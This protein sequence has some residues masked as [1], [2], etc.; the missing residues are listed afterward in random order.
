MNLKKLLGWIPV[1]CL[2]TLGL[3]VLL[4]QGWI[5][6][7]PYVLPSAISVALAI[8]TVLFFDGRW[9]RGIAT[10]I[11]LRI[12]IVASFLALTFIFGSSLALLVVSFRY[13]LRISRAHIASTSGDA[14][15]SSD[16][17]SPD[18]VGRVLIA[19]AEPFYRFY[20]HPPAYFERIDT[21]LYVTITNQT[22]APLYVQGYSVVALVRGQQWRSF[23]NL[24][25]LGLDPQEIG[26]MVP[27]SS[28]LSRID[29]TENGF[30]YLMRQKPL[31]P[32]QALE[33]WMFFNSGL[34]S[35][36]LFDVTQFRITIVDST[37]KQHTFFSDYPP[38][39]DPMV[40]KLKILPREPIPP[41]LREMPSGQH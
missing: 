21:E 5:R 3:G 6:S 37:Q 23:Q 39:G 2:G 28:Y 35:S 13:E 9:F 20:Q 31:G 29:L 38:Q 10:R 30:D 24:I 12:P 41:S 25:A 36:Y 1:F 32:H 34:T 27:K 18:V 11:I 22:A 26:M 7:N 16:R 17:P 19:T 4:D 33:A 8:W 40:G 14:A 15:T